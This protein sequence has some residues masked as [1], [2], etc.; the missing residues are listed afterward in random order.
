MLS[1]RGE[2]KKG[3]GDLLLSGLGRLGW[4]LEDRTL[5]LDSGSSQIKS[6]H[7]IVEFMLVIT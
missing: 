2:L 1:E 7:T 5:A 4:L 6:S 3:R